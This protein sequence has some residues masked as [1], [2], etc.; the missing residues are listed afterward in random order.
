MN[1]LKITGVIYDYGGV[2]KI[3]TIKT[4][5]PKEQ[6]NRVFSSAII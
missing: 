1:G 6:K 4:K 3:Q 5:R 2:K